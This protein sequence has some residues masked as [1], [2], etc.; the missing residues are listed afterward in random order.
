MKSL[1]LFVLIASAVVVI[2]GETNKVHKLHPRHV[3]QLKTSSVN[4]GPRY[5]VNISPG[6]AVIIISTNT[7]TDVEAKRWLQE[8]IRSLR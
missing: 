2:S 6:T 8:A 3:R 1:A 7:F 4:F 5:D